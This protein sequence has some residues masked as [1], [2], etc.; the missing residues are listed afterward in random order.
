[1]EKMQGGV[2]RLAFVVSSF[3]LLCGSASV[4]KDA[5]RA[6][7]DKLVKTLGVDEVGQDFKDTT[8]TIIQQLLKTKEEI[9]R[10]V[11]ETKEM[12]LKELERNEMEMK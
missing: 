10:K 2:V 3:V 9:S 1:V 8:D 12:V 7:L 5:T 11:T 6:K 4:L